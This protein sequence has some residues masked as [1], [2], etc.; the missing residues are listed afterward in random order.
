MHTGTNAQSTCGETD[1]HGRERELKHIID[2]D[3]IQ[4]TD[5]EDKETALDIIWV[6][7]ERGEGARSQASRV[8]G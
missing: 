3:A 2:F 1:V 7:D 5:L 8:C 4:N 6:E